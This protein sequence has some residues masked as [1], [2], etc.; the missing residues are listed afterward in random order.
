MALAEALQGYGIDHVVSS[1]YLRARQTFEPLARAAGLPLHLDDRLRERALAG[2]VVED[3][4]PALEKS[5]SDFDFCLAG[6]ESGRE[7][8]VRGRL[9]LDEIAGGGHRLAALATHG[10]LLTLLLHSID[11]DYGFESWQRLSNP[12]VF[13]LRAEGLGSF[14][15]ERVWPP[16]RA[17]GA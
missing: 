7:A 14:A 8:Q 6:G 17:G 10:N 12:D 2:E 15:I 4:L 16:G 11:R 5:F 3:F 9:A 1:P 13:L